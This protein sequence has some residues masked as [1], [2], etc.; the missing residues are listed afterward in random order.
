[1]S[2]S[3]TKSSDGSFEVEFEVKLN[4]AVNYVYNAELDS[5]E[6][7]LNDGQS[8]ETN[9]TTTIEKNEGKPLQVAF[10]NYVANQNA[11]SAELT[12][13]RKPVIIIEEEN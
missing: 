10:V 13:I 9:F 2:Y 7:H 6:I 5:Y 11:K 4:V 1:M 8:S 3:I 12:P